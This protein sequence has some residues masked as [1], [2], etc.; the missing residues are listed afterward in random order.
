MQ[1]DRSAH[2]DRREIL[3]SPKPGGSVWPQQRCLAFVPRKEHLS[4]AEQPVF[5]A[6]KRVLNEAP[7]HL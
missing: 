6:A 1:Y 3:P 5:T 4:I 7:V 2:G